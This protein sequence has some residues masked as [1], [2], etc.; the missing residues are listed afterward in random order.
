[1]IFPYKPSIL[2]YPHQWKPPFV[3]DVSANP[4]SSTSYSTLQDEEPAEEEEKPVPQFAIY[5][6]HL[7]PLAEAAGCGWWGGCGWFVLFWLWWGVGWIEIQSCSELFNVPW[8]IKSSF[9]VCSSDV[10]GIV[11]P[12][13]FTGAPLGVVQ[14]PCGCAAGKPILNVTL[15]YLPE[16]LGRFWKIILQLKYHSRSRWCFH[17]WR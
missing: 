10:S 4:K 2:G 5:G 8:F 11:T 15:A 9:E 7:V 3:V 16:A 13:D 12:A 1:M 17:K 6:P 14:G